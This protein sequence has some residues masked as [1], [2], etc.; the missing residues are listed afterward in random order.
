MIRHA[1]ALSGEGMDMQAAILN[2]CVRIHLWWFPAYGNVNLL[3]LKSLIKRLFLVAPYFPP[4][5]PRYFSCESRNNSQVAW[6]ELE[7]FHTFQELVRQEKHRMSLV[8]AANWHTSLPE[9]FLIS[10]LWLRHAGARCWVCCIKPSFVLP[11]HVC[12]YRHQFE[13]FEVIAFLFINKDVDPQPHRDLTPFH[14]MESG[15]V[16]GG[17]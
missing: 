12:S 5:F 11:W 9:V 10:V 2:N 14:Q 7:Y 13:L 3:H 17:C 6:N 4:E 8:C 15:T 16:D 1:T